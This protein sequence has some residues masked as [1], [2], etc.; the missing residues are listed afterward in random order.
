MEDTIQQNSFACNND[1]IHH[2]AF[3]RAFLVHL[4]SSKTNTYDIY[5]CIITLFIIFS[6]S[7]SI[8]LV[9]SFSWPCVLRCLFRLL[10]WLNLRSHKWHSKRDKTFVMTMARLRNLLK[11]SPK[12]FSP[13]WTLKLQW[14]NETMSDEVFLGQIY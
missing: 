14:N 1:N 6:I 4:L 5:C 2:I 3:Y 10:D 9:I 11:I 7:D 8:A 13:V 12:G